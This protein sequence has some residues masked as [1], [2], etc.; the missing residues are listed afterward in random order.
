[1]SLFRTIS[2]TCPHCGTDQSFDAAFS[3][4]ADR[5]P[6]FR[7]AIVSNEFQFEACEKCTEQFRLDPGFV[8]LDIGRG[9]W[10]SAQPAVALG[11]WQVEVEKAD[12]AMAQSYGEDASGPAQEIGAKLQA[13]VTFGWPALREKIIANAGGL[14]DVAL[15]LTKAALMRTQDGLPLSLGRELRLLEVVEE[16][17]VVAVIE[18]HSEIIVETMQLPIGFYETIAGQVDVWGDT[19]RALGQGKFVDVQKLYVGEGAE[20]ETAAE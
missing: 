8:Y 7:D 19:A 9:L 6:D 2:A 18:A 12:Q 4:N 5:R 17:L 14:D 13:R 15:E 1:M 20:V 11:H 10:I 3:V 16:K